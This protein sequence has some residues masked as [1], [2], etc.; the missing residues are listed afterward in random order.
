MQY[1][2]QLTFVDAILISSD[3]NI[4]HA[5]DHLLQCRTDPTNVVAVSVVQCSTM[6]CHNPGNE[7]SGGRAV[8]ELESVTVQMSSFNFSVES[9]VILTCI[10]LAT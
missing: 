4:I 3:F 8:D 5:F 9:N 6:F 2:P 1:V 7:V 10:L